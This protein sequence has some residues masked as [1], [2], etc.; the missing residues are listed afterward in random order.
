M[1][2]D[3]RAKIVAT[4]GPATRSREAL[5]KCIRAGM[6]VARLNFSHG[7]HED[8][9]PVIQH[10]RELS[11]ALQAPVTILQDLQ[12]PK[13]R[14]GKFKNG[15]IQL[16]DGE[17]VVIKGADVV[18]EPGLIPTDFYA[19]PTCVK[20]G[21]KILLDD[22][23]LEL[24]VESVRGDEVDATV[25]Y[26]GTLKDRKGLNVPGA[27]LPIES[28][29]EKDKKDLE[30]GLSQGVDYVALSFVRQARDI[31]KLREI[32]ESKK[33]DAR[34][35]AK[36]E[37][38]EALDHLEEI[39]RLSDAVM[40]ARGDLA[41]E[42]GQTQLPAWQKKIIHMCNRLRK[43]V[44]TATQMLDSMVENPRPTRAEITDVAN[45]VLDGSDALMLS[46]ESASG[47]Y[48]FKCI[49]TMHEIIKEAETTQSEYYQI[50]LESEFLSVS[51]SIGAS[52]ALCALKLNASA[53]V[54]L[55]STGKTAN[56]ISGFRPK[57]RII[58]ATDS[59][60]TLNKLELIWG[61]Q[62]IPISPYSSA[63]EAMA[64]IERKLVNYGLVKTGDQII[65]TLG[66]PIKESAKTNSL[67]VYTIGGED[68]GRLPEES[69]PL[70]CQV[71]E[72]NF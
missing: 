61:I 21:T 44:I 46:A 49:R 11:K 30:F 69:L 34:V 50:S 12:G 24:R 16:A 64:Q 39:V 51:A 18:G 32:I 2:A 68:L 62:T 17:K 63:A 36:I 43:P 10:L 37:M 47:K 57:A 13:I 1:L 25:I 52:S 60:P 41:I 31:R 15:S 22:G 66:Q 26:G 8:H 59:L 33:S 40:V 3:R 38:L 54:C 14:V 28:M 70:R 58:A 71:I 35:I 45:A 67:R 48:P 56:V 65:L 6:N 23:L 20:Q 7:S 55:T 29:T 42:V 5:E 27:N 9:L 19:L 4:I 53:I 72:G